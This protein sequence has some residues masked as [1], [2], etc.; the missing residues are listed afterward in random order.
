M[1][2]VNLNLKDKYEKKVIAEMM[3]KFG[4]KSRLNVPRLEKVAINVGIGRLAQAK[5]EKKIERIKNSFALIA[6]QK[7]ALARARKAIAGFKTR[8][9]MV[10]GFF[11]ILR[12]NRMYDFLDRLI[13]I[14]LP[15]TRDF[16]GLEEKSIDQGG[17]LTIGVKEHIVFPEI[18]AESQETMFGFQITVVSNAKKREEAVELFRLLGFPIKNG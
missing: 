1:S 7:P 6:G 2:N 13:Y 8:Q 9:G 10:I 17:N 3:E 14:A 11:A 12:G 5:D 16:R 15:R 4:Y 18:Q